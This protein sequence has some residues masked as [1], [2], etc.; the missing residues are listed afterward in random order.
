MEVLVD[1]SGRGTLRVLLSRSLGMCSAVSRDDAC[2]DERS[3]RVLPYKF[4]EYTFPSAILNV[5]ISLR[6]DADLRS[7]VRV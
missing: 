2:S 4:E 6:E 7:S 5:S 1:E 3:E